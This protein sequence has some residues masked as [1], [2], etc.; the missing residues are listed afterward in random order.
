MEP[1][2]RIVH[3]NRLHTLT[4]GEPGGKRTERVEAVATAF[5]GANFVSW[6]SDDIVQDM[7]EKWVFI[8]SCAGIT[9]LMRSS[10]G[11]IVAGGGAELSM[12][13]LAE[14]AAVA[15]SQGH[16]PGKSSLDM[17]RSMLTA[18][19]SP[20][21]ASMFRDI[22]R[23]ARIEASHLVGDLLQRGEQAG[24]ETPLLRVV[25]AHLGTY[26]MRRAREA[27]EAAPAGRE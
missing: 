5:S 6:L 17:S 23:G 14:C 15:G 7:W 27:A 13:L 20:L 22:E 3:F 16:E 4:F 2:G 11:D 8:A 19:N 1:G 18:A 10:I 21:V 25:Q 24:V 26:E 12:A 9:C